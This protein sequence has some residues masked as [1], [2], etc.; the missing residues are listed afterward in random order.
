MTADRYV[1]VEHDQSG[2]F[3][4][5]SFDDKVR[6]LDAFMSALLRV[7]LDKLEGERLPGPV[8]L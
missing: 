8:E 5:A 6:A 3:V 4:A 2:W 7:A 1:V